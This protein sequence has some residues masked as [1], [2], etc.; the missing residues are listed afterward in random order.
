MH[1]LDLSIKANTHK[2]T[3]DKALFIVSLRG[4][5]QENRAARQ[6]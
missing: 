2:T 4:Y 5:G 6:F 1:Y 3:I